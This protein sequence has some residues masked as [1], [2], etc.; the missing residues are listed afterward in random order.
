[1]TREQFEELLDVLSAHPGYTIRPAVQLSHEDSALVKTIETQVK[2]EE[3][4]ANL[5][6]AVM[7][8]EEPFEELTD[9]QVELL[10]GHHFAV[11]SRDEV[12]EYVQSSDA[13]SS[14]GGIQM[15]GTVRSGCPSCDWGGEVVVTHDRTHRYYTHVIVED[16]ELFKGR[17][18][19]ERTRSKKSGLVERVA[20]GLEVD[21]L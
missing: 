14:R 10:A 18:C 2:A 17:M 15:S 6:H 19:S 5:R 8:A 7:F 11:D 12:R 20:D 3:T 21:F 13:E 9:D 16:G 4:L 1:M